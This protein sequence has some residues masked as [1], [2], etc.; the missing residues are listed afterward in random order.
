M[1]KLRETF[2]EL[3]R[4]FMSYPDPPI[5][6]LTLLRDVGKVWWVV[7]EPDGREHRLRE[8]TQSEVRQWIEEQGDELVSFLNATLMAS[9]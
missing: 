7:V 6:R 9:K 5:P 4:S 1:R 3:L 2:A 8:A